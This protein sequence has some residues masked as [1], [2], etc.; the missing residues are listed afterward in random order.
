MQ[1]KLMVFLEISFNFRL[2]CRPIKFLHSNFEHVT[3]SEEL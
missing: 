2:R 3:A 1:P